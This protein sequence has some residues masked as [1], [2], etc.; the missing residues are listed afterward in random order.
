MNDFWRCFIESALMKA[1]IK[2]AIDYFCRSIDVFERKGPND[3]IA[4]ESVIYLA[5][6][7][8][9]KKKKVVIEKLTNVCIAL[10][11]GSTSKRCF[12]ILNA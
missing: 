9:N 6:N 11:P 10:E 5:E 1:T 12:W 7:E 4:S 3:T 2:L 8:L